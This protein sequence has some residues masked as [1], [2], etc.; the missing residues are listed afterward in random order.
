MT[1]LRGA[2]VKNGTVT[3]LEQALAAAQTKGLTPVVP[4]DVPGGKSVCLCG[5]RGDG[6]AAKHAGLIGHGPCTVPGCTCPKF[7]WGRFIWEAPRR[8]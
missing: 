5:H 8:S 6:S 2:R 7:S 4:G 1:K 3:T